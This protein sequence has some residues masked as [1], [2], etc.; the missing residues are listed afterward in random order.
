MKP[1]SG[2]PVR[3]QNIVRLSIRWIMFAVTILAFA[4]CESVR[5]LPK[6]PRSGQEAIKAATSCV[7]QTKPS[8]SFAEYEA[9]ASRDGGRRCRAVPFVAGRPLIHTRIS[10]YYVAGRWWAEFELSSVRGPRSLLCVR[11]FM[12]QV[13]MRLSYNCTDSTGL[14]VVGF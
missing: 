4:M 8:Y 10:V 3:R 6:G 11:Q 5:Y 1:A 14:Q 7:K 2:N 12:R 9:S 13:V